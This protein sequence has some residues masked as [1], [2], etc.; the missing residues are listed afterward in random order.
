MTL[1]VHIPWQQAGTQ[2]AHQRIVTLL[3]QPHY[4]TNLRFDLMNNVDVGYTPMIRK[5]VLGTEFNQAKA[6]AAQYPGRKWLLGQRVN[7]GN[8]GDPMMTS[9]QD[10]LAAA[11]NWAAQFGTDEMAFP[12]VTP[13]W[14]GSST[15]LEQYLALPNRVIPAV[16]SARIFE[17]PSTPWTTALQNFKNWLS[18]KGVL[19]P[20][21]IHHINGW[22]RMDA[23]HFNSTISFWYSTYNYDT[24]HLWSDSEYNLTNQAG[25]A[26]TAYGNTYKRV[27][28][29]SGS[30]V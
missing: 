16:W 17:T 3:G 14:D 22:A 7:G 29:G 21:W 20:V 30:V 2:L 6:V 18:S 11:Q 13:S 4:H 9:P 1:G 24:A 19:R 27:I 23:L 25:T 15:W 10:A 8:T 5:F 26:L 12:G 28:T